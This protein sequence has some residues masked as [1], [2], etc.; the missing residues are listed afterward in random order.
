MSTISPNSLKTYKLTQ[1]GLN[2]EIAFLEKEYLFTAFNDES[3]NNP[4]A[5]AYNL[6]ENQETAEAMRIKIAA[7][8]H[9]QHYQEAQFLVNDY[10]QDNTDNYA[11]FK[12]IEL[13][14]KQTGLNWFQMSV[15]QANK[16]KQIAGETDVYGAKNAQVILDL[17]NDTQLTEYI[18]PI[19]EPIE[20][21]Q[22][23]SYDYTTVNRNLLSLSPN[24]TNGEVYTS[25]ELPESYQ[26]AQL[27]I[28]N[29]MGQKV[30]I[31]DISGSKYL[32]RINCE[33]YTSGIYLVSL[34]ID[35]MKIESQSLSVITK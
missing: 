23:L 11:E 2:E 6:Y 8:V 21:R 17:I 18:L 27:E 12:L 7:L 31:L 4:Y 29:S 5:L 28:Y 32:S 16:L 22:A 26:Q 24:P 13:D 9:Q 10:A 15:N 34:V 33:Q 25:Y 20:M 19:A 3:I 14:L 35:G 1:K 30:D